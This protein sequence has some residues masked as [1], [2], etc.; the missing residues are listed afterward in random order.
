MNIKHIL[1]DIEGTTTK[2]T[3]VSE[4]L[5][6]YF[7]EHIED[8]WEELRSWE[9]F[10]LAIS[11]IK[12]DSDANSKEEFI[13]QLKTWVREDIKQTGLKRLQGKVWEKGYK[14]GDL[15]AHLYVDVAKAFRDW[16]NQGLSINIYSSGS[17]QA[18]KLLFA[19]SVYGDLTPMI[20]QYFDTK[21]G[22]KR[23]EKSYHE[24]SKALAAPA[25]EIIFFSDVEEELN[26]AKAAGMQ[27]ALLVRENQNLP[28][29]KHRVLRNFMGI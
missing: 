7:V 24:I 26:A 11:E 17:V 18:Q 3:F 19:N 28:S 4:V 1:T 14:K 13:Q 6:P 22:H 8:E 23:E 27:T 20:S 25:S 5:F 10:D 16:K 9:Q 29:S 21:I 12:K 2:I 15:K